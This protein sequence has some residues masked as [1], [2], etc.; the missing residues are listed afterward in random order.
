M[1]LRPC[2]I[3][4]ESLAFADRRPDSVVRSEIETAFDHSK[5]RPRGRAVSNAAVPPAGEAREKL[6]LDQRVE[7]IGAG[8]SVHRPESLRLRGC[9]AQSWHLEELSADSFQQPLVVCS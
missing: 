8:L 6:A 1:G 4:G 9:Q 2:R 7:K 3:L 5:R